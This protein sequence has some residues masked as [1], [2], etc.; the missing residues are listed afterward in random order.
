[1][2]GGCDTQRSLLL[3]PE[4]LL[5]V[6]ARFVACSFCKLPSPKPKPWEARVAAGFTLWAAAAR[7][8]L[9][10]MGHTAPLA[11]VGNRPAP[12]R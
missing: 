7:Q 11:L 10:C 4:T 12:L 9:G 3:L 5:A 1:M 2:L 6:G 8:I